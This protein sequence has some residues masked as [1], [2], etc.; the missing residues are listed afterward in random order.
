MEMIL[1]EICCKYVNLTGLTQWK[2]FVNV[3]MSLSVA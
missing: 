2:G 3:V 1:R